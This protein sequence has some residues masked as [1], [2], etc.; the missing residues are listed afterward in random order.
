MLRILAFILVVSGWVFGN[1]AWA[2]IVNEPMTG[3]SSPGW[4]IGGSAYLTASTGVDT[5]GDGWLR[6]TEPLTNQSGFAFFD[7]PFDIST[8]VVI[9]FD[10]A[11]WGG[12]GADGYSVFLFDGSYDAM[13]FAPGAS[14]G[15]LGYD[16]KTVAP[17][18]AGLTGGYIGI[19]IDEYGN[20]SNPTEGRLGGPGQQ[21][22]EVG[23]RGPYNHPSGAYYWLGGSGAIA[24]NQL[25][26]NNQLYRPIQY[27]LPIPQGRDQADAGRGAKLPAGRYLYPVRL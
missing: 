16:K 24:G 1:T 12:N 7:S 20:F 23:V 26:Y 9:Q 18:H 2:S 6:I 13:T 21:V 3:V 17:L 11:T 22:N 14:G 8:G 4:V 5:A 25:A 10:Y 15:S 27:S 19:G